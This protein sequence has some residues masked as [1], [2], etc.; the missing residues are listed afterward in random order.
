MRLFGSISKAIPAALAVTVVAA[1]AAAAPQTDHVGP[2]RFHPESTK[3]RLAEAAAERA[4]LAT[5]KVLAS[6][7]APTLAPSPIDVQRYELDLHLDMTRRRLSGTAT[8]E[9]AAVENGLGQVSLDMDLG[10]RA[11]SVVLLSDHRYPHDGPRALG[12]DHADDRLTVTLPRAL[13]AG[14]VVELSIAYGGTAS[15]SGY[16]V[17]WT[18]WNGTPMGYTFAEPFGARVWFPCNDRPDDKALVDLRVTVPDWATTASNGLL[19]EQTVNDDGSMSSTWSS[20]YP[21]ATYLVVLNVGPFVQLQHDYVAADGTT[22]PVHTYVFPEAADLADAALSNT[23]DMIAT[24]APLF[25]EYPFL[26]EK[27]GNCVTFFGGGMEHQ[28]LTTYSLDAL[29]SSWAPWLNVHELGHQWWGDWVTCDD[30]RELWLNEGF[31]T[32]TEW[33]WAEHLG[34]DVLRGYLEDADWR[35]WFLGPLYD[36]PVA[37]SSTVYDKGAWALRMLRHLLGDDEFFAGVA[38][39]RSRHAGGSATTADLQAAFEAASGEQLGWFF[40]QW[41]YGANRPRLQ[42]EWQTT[43][44]PGVRLTVTQEQT[45]AG[46]FRLPME[47]DVATT[48]GIERHRVDLPAQAETVLD[49]ELQASA[50]ELTFDPDNWLLAEISPASEPDLELGPDFPGPYDAGVVLGGRTSTVTVPLTNTG[51]STLE[52]TVLA[53]N[54]GASWSVLRPRAPFGIAPGETVEAELEFAPSGAGVQDDYLVIVSN[55]PS[56]DGLVVVPLTGTGTLSAGPRLATM[57]SAA[58]GTAPVG[59]TAERSVQVSN[60]GDEPLTL[61]GSIEGDGFALGSRLPAAVAPGRT[62]YLVFR[63]HP[64]GTGGHSGSFT[65]RTNDPARPEHVIALSGTGAA[66]ARVGL[67]PAALHLGLGAPP[68]SASILVANQGE[69]PLTVGAVGVDGPFELAGALA[70]PATVPA[71][72]TLEVPIRVR[73]G[74]DGELRGSLRVRTDDPSLTWAVA[75]LSAHVLDRAPIRSS[76][77]AAASTGGVGGARWTTDATL[78]NPGDDDLSVD[79][80]FRPAGQR[81][82]DVVDLALTVPAA[83]QRQ[84]ADVVRA[85]GWEGAGGIELLAENAGLVTVTRTFSR[86]AEGTYGQHIGSL[87]DDRLLTDADTAVLAGLAGNDGFHTNLGILNL[88]EQPVRVRFTLYAVDGTRLGDA[89]LTAIAGGYA[90]EVSVL[91]ALTSERIRGGWAEITTDDPGARYAAW[92]S[93]VDDGSHDPTFVAPVRAPADAMVVPAVAAVNGL[94]GT[95]WTSDVTLVNVGTATADVTLA[96]LPTGG[97]A[98]AAHTRRLSLAARTALLLENVVADLAGGQ[99]E[100][101]LR[102]TATAPTTALVATSRT[103]TSGAAGTYG[104]LVPAVPVGAVAGAGERVVVAGLRSTGGFRSNLGLTSLAEVGT[105]VTARFF[106]DL[107]NQIGVVPVVLPAGEFVQE[108]RVL[109]RILGYVGTAWVELSSDDAAAAYVAHVSVVDG[110]SGDPAYIPGIRSGT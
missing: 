7:W 94:G 48:A 10:L 101:V 5:S 61:D 35:G 98:P 89:E 91:A 63:F 18:S 24:L 29:D 31:A 33:L 4:R 8:V 45:N 11:L 38:E 93:V 57:A 104:Q 40:D 39:Y 21:V 19:V 73:P 16:G 3:H 107:G 64:P 96:Y 108:V 87:S 84:L 15:R 88:G 103:F 65:L 80:R 100:G 66:S 76:V 32:L 55:D 77:P 78:L 86:E 75:P 50:T 109:E 105:T 81:A 42:Y 95:V 13:A 22:M 6:S 68:E 1:G 99:G 14:D 92:A 36:N 41:V 17:T 30:W 60:L 53:A 34:P 79:L 83:G 72:G 58:L 97:P 71:S 82:D 20:R 106:D 85:M 49:L 27:Y 47:I 43:A 69:L 28:T 90:Q 54:S 2:E 37:F 59:G 74:A 102:I 25:G 12:W 110:T 56:R 9:L 46:L 51:G 52:V 70:L 23:P 62:E 26:Q 44:G 67:L